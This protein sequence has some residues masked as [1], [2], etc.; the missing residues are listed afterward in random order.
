VLGQERSNQREAIAKI[1]ERVLALETT[2]SLEERFNKLVH[3]VK[4]GFE[5]PQS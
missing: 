3:E 1:K 5:I 4:N 2:S